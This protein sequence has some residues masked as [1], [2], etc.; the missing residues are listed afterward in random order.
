M[1][2]SAR[3]QLPGTV[4]SVQKGAGNGL[5]TIEIAPGVV[6]TSDITNNAIDE[7]ELRE[8]SRAYAVVKAS[9]VMVGVDD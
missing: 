1:R 8:G 7:L 4:I 3:N 9:S 2:L 6:V 5:V